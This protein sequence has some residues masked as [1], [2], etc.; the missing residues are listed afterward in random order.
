MK[1]FCVFCFLIVED[2][3]EVFFSWG[4][5]S[6]VREKRQ[7]VYLL[8]IHVKPLSNLFGEKSFGCILFVR[9]ENGQLPL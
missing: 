5:I 7:K 9:I 4:D 6:G 3:G 2:V 1:S 8:K